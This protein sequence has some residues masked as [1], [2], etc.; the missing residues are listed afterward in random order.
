[1]V[2]SPRSAAREGGVLFET[3]RD[4]VDDAPDVVGRIGWAL[5]FLIA[6]WVINRLARRVIDRGIEELTEAREERAKELAAEEE[7]AAAGAEN[8]AMRDRAVARSRQ[9]AAANARIRQRTETLGAVLG[10]VATIIIYS[11]AGLLALAQFNVNLGPLVVSA[12]VVGIALGFGAQSLVKDFLSGVFILI[13]DQYGVGDIVDL[14]E[15]TGEVEEVNLRTT[16][17][18]DLEGTLWHVPNGEIR[19]VANK[20]QSWSRVVLDIE[21]AYDTDLGHATRV[22]KQV[23]DDIWHEAPPHATVLEEPEIKGIERFGESAVAIRL[24]MKVEPS[25][26]FDAARVVRT[27]LKEAFE[28]ADIEIPFPQRTIWI[29]KMPALDVPDTSPPD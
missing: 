5:A 17:V 3:V 4:W 10:N 19:R 6:A 13:E 25:E 15:A 8:A 14:G 26:Q 28:A 9:R 18:R 23:A 21:V 11:I 20:S 22:I 7:A 16:Q 29:N 2:G 1:M 12:G 27:R 24:A